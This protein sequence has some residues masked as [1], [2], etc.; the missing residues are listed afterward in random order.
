MY[1]RTYK[2]LTKIFKISAKIFED[3]SKVLKICKTSCKN[4]AKIC[5]TVRILQRFEGIL[6]RSVMILQR[7]LRI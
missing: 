5:I 4:L 3:L 7:A 1:E 2:D 6:L